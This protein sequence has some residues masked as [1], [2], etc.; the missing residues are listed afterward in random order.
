[1]ASTLHWLAFDQPVRD[2]AKLL[3]DQGLAAD[4]NEYMGRA[5][6]T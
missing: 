3:N 6:P 5:A 4:M 1:V 2:V